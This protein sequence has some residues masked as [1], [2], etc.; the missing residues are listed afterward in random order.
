MTS[1]LGG[2]M[3]TKRSSPATYEVEN[4]D[5]TCAQ[6]FHPHIKMMLKKTLP[7]LMQIETPPK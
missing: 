1:V 5:L 2:K 6:F 3:V 7:K 4:L